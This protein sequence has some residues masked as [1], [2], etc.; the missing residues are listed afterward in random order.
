LFVVFLPLPQPRSVE[1]SYVVGRLMAHFNPL[2]QD[3][4]EFLSLKG[5][6]NIPIVRYPPV[7]RK[8]NLGLA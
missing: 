8:L 2:I 7:A 3:Y 1:T 6:F 4:G 5:T